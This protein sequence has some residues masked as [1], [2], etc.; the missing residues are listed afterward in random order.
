M[1]TA[2]NAYR[3]K[4]QYTI[5]RGDIQLTFVNGQLHLVRNSLY[6]A[7]GSEIELDATGTMANGIQSPVSFSLIGAPY[8]IELHNIENGAMLSIANDPD[9]TE[10]VFQ[11]GAVLVDEP[12]TSQTWQ[13][14]VD[15]WGRIDLLDESDNPVD[16]IG[17]PFRFSATY[18][19]LTDLPDVAA[20]D[21]TFE[22]PGEIGMYISITQ[23]NDRGEVTLTSIGYVAGPFTLTASI[24]GWDAVTEWNGRVLTIDS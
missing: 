19:I 13:V 11:L 20:E 17:L 1:N 7:P 16:F 24:N 9:L 18:K 22:I 3:K 21:I 10:T 5:I 6:T 2:L 23:D 14:K 8:G 12:G 4:K 15:D